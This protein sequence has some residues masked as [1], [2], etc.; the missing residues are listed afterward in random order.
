M[1]NKTGLIVVDLLNDFMDENGSLFCGE[2]C[3][4]IIPKI[5]SR[6]N[7]FREKNLPIIYLQDS[8]KEDDLEFEK[9]PRHCVKNTWGSEIIEELKPGQ[10]DIIIKKTRFS[11][12]YDTSLADVLDKFSL[13]TLYVT[14]V[15]TSICV[16]DTI[17]GLSNRDYEVIVPKEE[18]ADFDENM[19][20]FSLKRIENLYGAK[21]V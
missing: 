20:E 2:E 3:K 19:H 8:H 12:F 5:K 11:G 1:N 14:G 9:F 10:D 15:C 21:I 17:G 13:E 7:E 16:M 4:N 18:V 6:I